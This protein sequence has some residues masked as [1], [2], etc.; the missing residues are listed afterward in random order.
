M[1][2]LMIRLQQKILSRNSSVICKSCNTI[3]K[4]LREVSILNLG[5]YVLVAIWLGVFTKS[6][7]C[8]LIPF[9]L[10][11]IN[12]YVARPKCRKCRSFEV[13]EPTASDWEN[14]FAKTEEITEEEIIYV[15]CDE[16]CS[17]CEEKESCE[18]RCF[19]EQ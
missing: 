17:C 3:D 13:V 16:N 1:T 15:E 9:V 7:W 2:Q 18:H 10:A 8:I 4:P 14:H 19:I 5:V 11:V 12:A 6:W